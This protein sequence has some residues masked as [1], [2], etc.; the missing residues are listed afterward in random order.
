M[1]I[2]RY[3]IASFILIVLVGWYVYSFITQDSTS[4]EIL[5]VALP[6]LSIAT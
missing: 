2:K 1:Y 5:G 3:T 6:S 4:V